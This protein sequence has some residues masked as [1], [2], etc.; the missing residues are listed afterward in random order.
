MFTIT[1]EHLLRFRAYFDDKMIS[2]KNFPFDFEKFDLLI[3]L[4]ASLHK[5][6]KNWKRKDCANILRHLESCHMA[7][8]CL[9][10]SRSPRS[11]ML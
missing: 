6:G 5:C 10:R 8:E 7:N 4:V 9:A 11:K 2:M 3:Y 1:I